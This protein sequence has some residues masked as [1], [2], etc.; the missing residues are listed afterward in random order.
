MTSDSHGPDVSDRQAHA[1]ATFTRLFGPRDVNAPEDDPELMSI[2]R[3]FIFGDVFD[4]GVLDDRARELVTVTVLA[5]LQTLPQLKAHTTAA[6]H[7]GVDPIEIRE[8]VYQ[9]APFIGFPRTLNAVATINE[10]FR[11]QGIELPLPDQGTVTDADRYAR[12]FAEQEPLYG[13][14][15]KANLA[16]L[17]EPFNEA[18]PRF[19]TEFCFGDF[20]TR[21]G[22]SLA[23]RELL[24]LCALATIGDTSA[25]LGPHARACIQVGNS[26]AYVIAALVHCFPYIGFPRAVAAIRA[27]KSL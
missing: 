16:D 26:T 3:G 12:G 25:Q 9:L 5:C 8:A 22:L 17:P 23:Q 1:E 15:I 7:V 6:L 4:T 27:V 19:L 10:A 21:G 14:E 18:L 11:A 24:V 13:D 20:Y 2:L